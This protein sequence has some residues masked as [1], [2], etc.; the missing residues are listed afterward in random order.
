MD[1]S[2]VIDNF[3]VLLGQKKNSSGSAD[4]EITMVMLV[5]DKRPGLVYLKA[6]IL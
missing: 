2:L 5:I 6:L 4:S 3:E 1:G